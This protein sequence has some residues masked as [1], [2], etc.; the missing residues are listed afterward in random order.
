MMSR[1][2]PRDQRVIVPYIFKNKVF[3][4][5]EQKKSFDEWLGEMH[6]AVVSVSFQQLLSRQLSYE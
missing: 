2:E 4:L 6:F 1:M 5:D 3:N